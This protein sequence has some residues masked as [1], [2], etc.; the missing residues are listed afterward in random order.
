[1]F[2]LLKKILDRI[3]RFENFKIR[4]IYYFK[5]NEKE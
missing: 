3:Y 5:I 2:A 1:M 4:K